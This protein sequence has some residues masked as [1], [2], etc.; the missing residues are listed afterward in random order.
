V[1]SA[2]NSGNAWDLRCFLREQLIKSIHE[3]YPQ[4]L[5]KA[6]AVLEKEESGKIAEQKM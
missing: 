6:R 1:V 5:P 3:H 4:C 2:G